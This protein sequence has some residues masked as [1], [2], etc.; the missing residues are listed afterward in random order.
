MIKSTVK[1]TNGAA[2][3]SLGVGGEGAESGVDVG[4]RQREHVAVVV[5]IGSRRLVLGWDDR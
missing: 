1:S 4:V 2:A 5:G 3:E